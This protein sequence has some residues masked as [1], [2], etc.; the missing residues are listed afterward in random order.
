MVSVYGCY[1]TIDHLLSTEEVKSAETQVIESA[2]S[3]LV[4]GTEI[5]HIAYCYRTAEFTRPTPEI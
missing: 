2:L 3:K 4:N 1:I 5:F